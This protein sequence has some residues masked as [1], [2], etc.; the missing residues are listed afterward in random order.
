V[1]VIEF[2][3]SITAA[4]APPPRRVAPVAFRVPVEYRLGDL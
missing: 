3:P 2:E 4:S 1:T